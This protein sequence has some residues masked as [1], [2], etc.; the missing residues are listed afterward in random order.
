MSASSIP[1][2]PAMAGMADGRALRVAMVT[3][4]F[5]PL[6][7]GVETHV[8]EVAARLV[9]RGVAVTVITTDLSGQLAAEERVRGLEVRRLAAAPRLGDLHWAPEVADAVAAG[10]W[11]LVH[12]Q[13]IHT[14]LPALAMRAAR[15]TGIPYLVT[16]HSGGHSSRLRNAIRPLQWRLQRGLL[17]GAAGLVAVSEFEAGVFARAAGLSRERFSVI[18]NGFEMPAA[19]PS[20]GATDGE[21]GPAILSVGRLERYKGHHRAIGAM[22]AV[23]RERPA[24]ELHIV[25]SGPYERRL[26]ELARTSPAAHRIRFDSFPPER[27]GEL[28]A[29]MGR[30]ELVLLL[31]EYEAN[32]V[33]VMEA[34]GLR[35]RVLVGANSGLRE[36]AR[37]GLAEEVSLRR[38]DDEIGHMITELLR[39]PAP[40]GL[41]DLPTW[42]GCADALL[43]LY[44]RARR[45]AGASP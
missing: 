14:L 36:L 33:T 5:H 4:R 22:E 39:R 3:P 40:A 41:P 13:G 16:F 31:S 17:R 23:L 19:P 32:P 6:T 29:L 44:R 37:L 2:E 42:D 27:R 24:A 30:S 45:G 20:D 8:H 34:A 26:R 43:D 28:R 11:D 21:P 10:G 1:A 18:R 15:G 9:R 38:G 25:G 7:G 35:R 12:V